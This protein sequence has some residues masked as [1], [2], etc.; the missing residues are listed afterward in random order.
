MEKNLEMILGKSIQNYYKQ[1][2]LVTRKANDNDSLRVLIGSMPTYQ[3]V[4][5][6]FKEEKDNGNILFD[7]GLITYLSKHADEFIQKSMNTKDYIVEIPSSSLNNTDMSTCCV[8]IL[9]LL[10]ELI[11]I[12]MLLICALK[13]DENK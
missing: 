4:N 11:S 8:T 6:Y 5:S 3:L 12:I 9:N 1:L 13:K 2:E 7:E 10:E